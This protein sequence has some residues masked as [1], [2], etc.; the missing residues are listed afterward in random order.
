[1]AYVKTPPGGWTAETAP[2]KAKTQR[3]YAADQGP[4]TSAGQSSSP[5]AYKPSTTNYGTTGGPVSTGTAM[6]SGKDG[7]KAAAA[8]AHENG[9]PFNGESG[10]VSVPSRVIGGSSTTAPVPAMPGMLTIGTDKNV[11]TPVS[12]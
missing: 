7:D 8:T 11:S 1:M 5:Q 12:G 3:G 6:N 10:A 9:W 2:Y 4:S